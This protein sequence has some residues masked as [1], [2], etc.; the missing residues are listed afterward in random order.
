[1][2]KIATEMWI[3]CAVDRRHE[4]VGRESRAKFEG[5]KKTNRRAGWLDCAI[6]EPTPWN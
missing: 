2:L 3:Y 4:A 1:M 5:T 6:V